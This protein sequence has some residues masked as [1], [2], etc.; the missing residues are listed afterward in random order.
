MN[1]LEKCIKFAL[2]VH[3][4]QTDRYG[5]PYI[6]HP[7]HLMS[8]MDTE[9]EMM[10][11]VLHDVIEDS[12]TTLDDLRQ[13]GLPEE[14]VE[15]VSLLTH[16]EADSYDDYVRKL[17]LNAVARKIKLADLAHNMDI[18]RM[19]KVTEKDAVRLDKYRRAWE[20]LT[21]DAQD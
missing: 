20:I 19:D 18:R 10:A 12:E 17:K 2:E 11:A 9:V 21:T 15:V 13:L 16:D 6:L 7:L 3:A 5:L 14:V 1:L 8:Q 4:G